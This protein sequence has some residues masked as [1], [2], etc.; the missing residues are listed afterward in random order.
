MKQLTALLAGALIAAT[1]S[2]APICYSVNSNGTDRL[3]RID[4]TTGVATDLGALSFIDAEGVEIVNGTIYGIGG[5]TNEFW[6]LTTPPGS[7]IGATG[8]RNGVDAGLGYNPATG[9]LYNLNGSSGSSS[10]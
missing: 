9:T 7:L 1:L 4:L 10:L 8:T 3:Y 2:A 6:N 5:T